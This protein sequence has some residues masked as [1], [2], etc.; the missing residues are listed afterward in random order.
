MLFL[1]YDMGSKLNFFDSSQTYR[2]PNSLTFSNGTFATSSLSISSQSLE[3]SWLDYTRDVI[4][5]F[6]Y[7][8][9]IST[10]NQVL[11]SATF[12]RSS[13]FQLSFMSSDIS[14]SYF[15]I[16]NLA[17]N[18]GDKSASRFIA[19]SSSIT[20]STASS[21]WFLYKYL[22]IIKTNN[23]NFHVS[24]GDVLNIASGIGNDVINANIIV[25]NIINISGYNY[26]YAYTEFND[27]VIDSI[28]SYTGSFIITNLNR[29]RSQN[30][31]VNN[32]S[33]HPI[34]VGY[35]LT[36][37]SFGDMTLST[38][39]NNKTSYYNMQ[40]SVVA[41]GVTYSMLYTD[42]FLKFGYSPTYNILDY[43]TS[44]NSNVF[45]GIKEYLALPIY[46]GLPVGSLTSSNIFIDNNFTTNTLYF[47]SDLQF[48][49]E[50]IFINT[51]VDIT[52]YGTSTHTK[53]KLLVM[54]KYYD[55]H[56]IISGQTQSSDA[57]VI[58]FHKAAWDLSIDGF[59]TLTSMD[60][61]SRR[62]LQQISSDLQ[63]LNNIQRP[64]G[65]PRTIEFGYTYENYESEL[66]FK[67]PT[68]SYAK[69]LLSDAETI[70]ELSAMVYVDYKNELSLNITKLGREY[71]TPILNTLNFG[72][73]LYISCSQKH[74]LS[75]GNGVS[76][77]FTGGTG[78]SQQLNQQYFGYHVVTVFNNYDFTV[79]LPYGVTPLVGN[80]IGVVRYLKVDP[81]LDYTPIDIIN[82]GADLAAE[83]PVILR[84]EN[85][86]LIGTTFSLINVN[87][88]EFRFRLIDG[89][90]I[91][92]IT[93]KYSWLLEA[94]IE[95]AIIGMDANQ[96]MIWY[97]GIW[98]GGRW[99]GGNWKSGTWESGDWYDGVWES[100]KITDKLLTVAVDNIVNNN[101]HS[102]WYDGRWFGGT[103]S[104]GT[105]DNGRWYGGDWSTGIWYNGI[106]NDGIWNDGQ[107]TGGVWVQG[108]WYD[109]VFNT[110]N[111]PAYWI[112]G[113]W[114]GGDFENGMWY[115]GVFD[116]RNGNISRFGTNAFNSRTATWHNGTW[117]SGEFHS[118]LNLDSNGLPD[119]SLTHK[120]SIWNTGI[121]SSGDWYGGIA[122][123][124]DFRSGVWHGGILDD[125]EIIGVDI[126][127]NTFTLNGIFKYNIG[128]IL[129]IIDN[130]IGNTYSQYGSNS[131]PGS[132]T[133]LNIVEDDVNK[134]TVV[135]VDAI[136]SGPSAVAPINIG[137]RVVSKFSGSNWKSGIWTNGL[138]NNNGLWEG[139][140]WY[141]GVFDASSTWS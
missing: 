56:P 28:K 100:R 30:D 117:V 102:N 14:T 124:I 93:S 109:G 120:F 77:E 119:V 141:N 133:I 39:F 129:N 31:L 85:I 48:E 78:S 115:S 21:T 75:T 63:E 57:Y 88:N 66:N 10:A 132:Y 82:I 123:D 6:E 138:F 51:F 106:W 7:Y 113:K 23:A 49:W 101:I 67:F 55:S 17:P 47:G 65:S 91:N 116:E 58:K 40:A 136:L 22:S 59:D 13:A 84:P 4:K 44:I 95:K 111:T 32:F 24:V 11:F 90:N 38:N 33:I 86:Q 20:A 36:Q 25:N 15:D 103:W 69:A 96:S 139:G 72:G 41:G 54:D 16:V 125:I 26:L 62:S 3:T 89:M 12:S 94:D 42:A 64:I 92:L 97:N 52:L 76:L 112:D 98:H 73:I 140:I 71:E 87:Y 81:F 37:D 2:T 35:S 126:I 83:I 110:N 118:M 61:S 128:N 9:T 43:L 8:T 127:N 29:Y 18:I 121:W 134:W 1:D 70:Q 74:G 130:Q 45:F 5:T 79:D 105:W 50:S 53:T 19:G 27:G 107:F 135:Y 34:G 46:N 108:T 80:D 60:I 131:L 99:F 104:G 137:L 114:Y 122:Y 68:D